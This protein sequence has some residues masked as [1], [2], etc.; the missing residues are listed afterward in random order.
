MIPARLDYL[1]MIADLNRWGIRDYKI[2][3]ICALNQGLIAKLKCAAQRSMGYEKAARLYNFW[4]DEA[5][6]HGEHVPRGTSFPQTL[7]ATTS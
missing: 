3:N 1:A 5:L 4:L 2:E 6:A 7:D